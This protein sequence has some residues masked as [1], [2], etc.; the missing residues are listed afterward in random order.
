MLKH[1]D[2]DDFNMIDMKAKKVLESLYEMNEGN[3]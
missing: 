3:F 2:L 1:F